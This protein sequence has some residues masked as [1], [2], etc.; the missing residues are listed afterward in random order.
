MDW[1][2][3]IKTNEKRDAM[4]LGQHISQR[5][6]EELEQ[7]R[8]NVLKMGGLVETQTKNA[9]KALLDRDGKLALKV[10]QS[11]DDVNQI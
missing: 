7:I 8:L 1:I 11:D 2:I 4:E 10:A 6:N 3:L 5:Y 9:I